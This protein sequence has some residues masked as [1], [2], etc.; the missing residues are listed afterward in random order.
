VCAGS[1]ANLPRLLLPGSGRS[2][3]EPRCAPW[4]PTPDLAPQKGLSEQYGN[5]RIDFQLLDEGED[6][7]QPRLKLCPAW[8]STE[9][10][11]TGEFIAELQSSGLSAH[12]H[13][14]ASDLIHDFPIP[15]ALSQNNELA[16]Q[17][18]TDATLPEANHRR[19]QKPSS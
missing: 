16:N 6:C 5:D 18:K 15:D 12:P 14:E 4:Q 1:V 11:E 19:E 10:I 8:S 9:G 13:R 3:L 2:E 7:P 17:C